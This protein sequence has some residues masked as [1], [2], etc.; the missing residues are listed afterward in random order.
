MTF[1]PTG[2][3]PYDFANRRHIGPSPSE[4]DEMLSVIGADSLDALIDAKGHNVY[5]HYNG[6]I[7]WAIDDF[8]D[9]RHAF[10]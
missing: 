9:I 3:D 1:T 5:Y 4:M 10:R 7:C 8:G 2:Y 6:I